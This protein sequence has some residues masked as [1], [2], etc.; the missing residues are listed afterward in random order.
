MNS[1]RL[2]RNRTIFSIFRDMRACD[3]GGGRLLF[4]DIEAEWVERGHPRDELIFGLQVLVDDG[5]LE[6]QEIGRDSVFSVTEKGFDYAR[7]LWNPVKTIS[8]LAGYL[9]RRAQRQQQID[10]ARIA[11]SA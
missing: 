5:L 2:A 1:D 10:I 8:G 11:Q 7:T 9:I 3:S 4:E 6:L